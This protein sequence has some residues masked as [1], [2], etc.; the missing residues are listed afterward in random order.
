MRIE[1]SK[2]ICVFHKRIE[3]ENEFYYTASDAAIMQ[4]IPTLQTQALAATG[5]T[6]PTVDPRE[7][8]NREGDHFLLGGGAL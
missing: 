1:N 4:R 2:S 6:R 3:H 7:V 5:N 8:R